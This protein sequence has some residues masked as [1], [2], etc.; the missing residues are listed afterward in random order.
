MGY[1]YSKATGGFYNSA[2]HTPAQ[3]PGDAVAV[4][5]EFHAALMSDQGAGKRIAGRDDGQPVSVERVLDAAAIKGMV[6]A[7][8][9]QAQGQ[10]IWRTWRMATDDTASTRLSTAIGAL[11]DAGIP[12]ANWKDMDGVFHAL[13]LADLKALRI[14]GVMHVQA[15]FD[16]E[17]TLVNQIDACVAAAGNLRAIDITGGWP[18]M[19]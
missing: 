16:R 8:R 19:V 10:M 17:S 1:F 9:Y 5:D 18:G 6:A 12:G 7:R 4:S 13:S 2:V 3:I 15:C 11:G 14:A